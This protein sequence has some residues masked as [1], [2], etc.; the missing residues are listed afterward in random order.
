MHIHTNGQVLM[1]N[2]NAY[3]YLKKKTNF[4]SSL[5]DGKRDRSNGHIFDE[6]QQHLQNVWNIFDFNTFEDFH[7]H[8]FKKD[9]LLLADV[10]EKFV[11]KCLKYYDLD[12]SHYFSAPGLSWDAILKMTGVA[13]EK[14][15]DPDKYM[16]F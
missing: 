7:N 12:P 3:L 8:Y 9:V 13:L 14:I 4:Y 6:Q 1:E 10:F 5:K 16:F 11:F 15:S 2:L